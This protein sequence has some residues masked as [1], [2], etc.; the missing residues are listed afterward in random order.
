MIHEH[1]SANQNIH[2]LSVFE[3]QQKGSNFMRVVEVSVDSRGQF[4]ENECINLS[5]QCCSADSALAVSNTD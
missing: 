2:N 5:L 1:L 4:T 3:L